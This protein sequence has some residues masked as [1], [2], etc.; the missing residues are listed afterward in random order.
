MPDDADERKP[1]PAGLV[2]QW[3][4]CSDSYDVP[5]DLFR[6]LCDAHVG[7]KSTNNLNLTCQWRGCAVTCA[8]RD[9]ITS[10]MRGEWARIDWTVWMHSDMACRNTLRNPASCTWFGSAKPIP[11]LKIGQLW[12]SF[13]H[14]CTADTAHTVYNR[15]PSLAL[16]SFLLPRHP[17]QSRDIRIRG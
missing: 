16:P 12:S 8:K 2:C 15:H 10:H 17:A 4:G 11:G 13:K 6:H 3:E 9:H 7:R 5:E 14:T 1:A